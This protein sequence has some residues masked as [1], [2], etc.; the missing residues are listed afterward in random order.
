MIV[1]R[2]LDSNLLI[3]YRYQIKIKSIKSEIKI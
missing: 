1:Y 3:L 2:D